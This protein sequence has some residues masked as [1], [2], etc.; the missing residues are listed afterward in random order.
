MNAVVI[1]RECD[2]PAEKGHGEVA[3]KLQVEHEEKHE[4]SKKKV[5]VT[6]KEHGWKNE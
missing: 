1:K 4:I 6:E 3:E 5:V 2:H